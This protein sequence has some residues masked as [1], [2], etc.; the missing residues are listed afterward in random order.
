MSTKKSKTEGQCPLQSVS[1]RSLLFD[2]IERQIIIDF[3][4]KCET[5]SKW[6]KWWNSNTII[7]RY[8]QLK[9]LRDFERCIFEMID[10]ALKYNEYE[11]IN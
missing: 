6:W 3:Y 11:T 10:K 7:N 1:K 2:C 5:K 8:E 4:K 9:A